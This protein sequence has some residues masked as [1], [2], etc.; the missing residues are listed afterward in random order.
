MWDVFVGEVKIGRLTEPRTD[1]G[2]VRCAFEPTTA[3][4]P[5][6]DAFAPGEIWESQNDALDAVIDE[7]AVEGVFLVGDDGSEIADP[8]LRV[9]GNAAWFQSRSST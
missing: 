3:F 7:I 9:D 1:G 2:I 4:D 6:A 5:Y 8:D